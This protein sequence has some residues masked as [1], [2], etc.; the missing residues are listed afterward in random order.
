[1]H[2]LLSNRPGHSLAQRCVQ[3]YGERRFNIPELFAQAMES[4]FLDSL[5]IV[6]PT[7]RMVRHLRRETIR[8]IWKRWKKPTPKLQLSTYDAFV[9]N[10]SKRRAAVPPHRLMSDAFRF[11]LFREA[12]ELCVQK[13]QLLFYSRDAQAIN[14]PVAQRLADIVYGL[15]KKGLEPTDIAADL[16]KHHDGDAESGVFHYARLH[17][18]HRIFECYEELRADTLLDMPSLLKTWTQNLHASSTSEPLASAKRVARSEMSDV[19]SV[20][21]TNVSPDLSTKTGGKLRSSESLTPALQAVEILLDGFSEFSIPELSC[22]V[23]LGSREEV[24]ICLRLDCEPDN[25]ELFGNMLEVKD[26]LVSHGW[27]LQ[28]L[29][30]ESGDEESSLKRLAQRRLFRS[31]VGGSK[32]TSV[33]Q[34]PLDVHFIAAMDPKDEVQ[35]LA[36]YIKYCVTKR[37]VAPQDIAVAL[38]QPQAYA[39][40]FR[41]TFE[42]YGIP[43]NLSDR[44]SLATA[45]VIAAAFSVLRLIVGDFRRSDV[46]E[47]LSSPFISFRSDKVGSSV[48]DVDEIAQR[49]RIQGGAR[50][51]GL[52]GWIQSVDLAIES[53]R[54]QLQRLQQATE[55]VAETNARRRELESLERLR[56]D[57]DYFAQ[58]LPSRRR[59]CTAEEFRAEFIRCC[60]DAPNIESILVRDAQ[61]VYRLEGNENER[62]RQRELVEQNTRAVSALME[63]LDELVFIS[64]ERQHGRK[65]FEDFADTLVTSV[66]AARVQIRERGNSGVSVTSIEQTRGIPFRIMIV[67]GMLDGEFPLPYTPQYFLGKELDDSEVR[68]TRAERMSLYHAVANV[69]DGLQASGSLGENARGET[70]LILS[71]PLHNAKGEDCVVSGF[72]KD[73]AD[74]LGLDSHVPSTHTLRMDLHQGSLESRYEWYATWIDAIATTD[75]AW[76]AEGGTYNNL[77]QHFVSAGDADNRA[78]VMDIIRGYRGMLNSRQPLALS[79]SEQLDLQALMS[80]PFSASELERFAACPY[81]YF[82]SKLLKLPEDDRESTVL[83]PL[84]KG[85]LLHYIVYRF[86]TELAAQANGPEALLLE[87]PGRDSRVLCVRL[88]PDRADRYLE[89]IRRIAQE[90]LGHS[91]I[92]HPFFR[93]TEDEIVGMEQ[94]LP[95]IVQR[96]LEEELER[97]RRWNFM[98]FV[99]EQGFG[100]RSRSA[101]TEA[102]TLG[103]ISLQGKVD[104]VELRVTSEGSAEFL[105]A[106]YKSSSGGMASTAEMLQHSSFQIPLYIAAVRQLLREHMDIEAR[107]AGGVYYIFQPKD[108][109]YK[110]VMLERDSDF[111]APTEHGGFVSTRTTSSLLPVGMSIEEAIDSSVEAAEEMV[112]HIREALFPV[113]PRSPK[114]CSHCSYSRVCRIAE[115]R[116]HEL[117]DEQQNDES[118]NEFG[119]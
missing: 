114:S 47:C 4:Q 81:R 42:S 21:K 54:S 36:R 60:L 95:G 105:I 82:A 101:S 35:S 87:I 76:G 37:G 118:E 28:A 51:G 26:F 86:Y 94:E 113:Q 55:D 102:I 107:P 13:R 27:E 66:R 80:R 74:L 100:Q 68:H 31:G 34:A 19:D 110:L 14:L 45:P 53:G 62:T 23:A 41:E 97:S 59:E 58:L 1:M 85:N 15:K 117:Q 40:L 10:E 69:A 52:Q 96:W 39:A 2:Y 46:S 116:P 43:I 64:S 56:S 72:V 79:E 17:D 44:A 90:E 50:Y 111:I 65:R 99:F 30:L 22:L 91:K 8:H 112:G 7:G 77:V 6:V 9:T 12:I 103:S 89:L 78:F 48:H 63:L 49:L 29:E 16:Q 83:S 67:C 109:T 5:Q 93:I 92:H 71:W 70:E 3:L 25:P 20:Q 61:R 32:E 38:R 119:A 57:L 18:I 73:L 106:D 108:N 98:P 88:H 115:I 84:E 33:W 104:R 24:S 11:T 75:D